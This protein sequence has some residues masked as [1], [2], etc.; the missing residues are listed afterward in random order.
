VR[1]CCG[2]WKMNGL[3]KIRGVGVIGRA[4]FSVEVLLD[5][6]VSECAEW[7][8]EFSPFENGR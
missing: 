6:G 7:A 2:T 5:L 4:P 1:A 8:V 3:D